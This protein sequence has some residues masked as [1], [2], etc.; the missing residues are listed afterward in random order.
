[1]QKVNNKNA[2]PRFSLNK[3]AEYEEANAARRVT[4]IEQQKNPANFIAARYVDVRTTL[5]DFHLFHYGD[6]EFLVQAID[7]LSIK[8]VSTTWQESDR[9]KSV[10]ALNKFLEMDDKPSLEN[11]TFEPYTGKE[12]YI[13]I[14]GV[15]IS[16]NPDVI[17]RGKV[18]GKEKIGA[19]KFNVSESGSL[20]EMGQKYVA[21][22]L[23][24]FLNEYCVKE[25]ESVSPKHCIS[26][27][28][29]SQ[30]HSSAPKSCK[31]LMKN[32]VAS[33][34]EINLRWNTL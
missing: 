21:T 17:L 24:A 18:R 26:I 32:I 34:Q 30:S 10:S 6:D 20:T 19:L 29:F 1:M 5:T 3:L 27:D 23:Q 4:L 15:R 22:L 16:V 13:E 7:E 2:K 14:E 9:D 12:K 33:C 8:S 28:I 11:F 31:R 25:G